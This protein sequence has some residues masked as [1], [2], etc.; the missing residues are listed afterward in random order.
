MC[1]DI[2]V[3]TY[4]TKKPVTVWKVVDGENDD[5][6]VCVITKEL[7]SAYDGP[8]IDLSQH[9][10]WDA[11][12]RR[13]ETHRNDGGKPQ[14]YNAGFHCPTSIY[15]ANKFFNFFPWG[16]YDDLRVC[17]YVIPAGTKVTVGYS[18]VGVDHL[19]TLVA[20]TLINP[21]ISVRE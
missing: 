16:G 15:D 2:L 20:D 6:E 7:G 14:P 8:I 21:R 18:L 12:T 3:Y 17:E 4:T 1:L 10:R 5:R 13:R 19:R 9:H 11:G